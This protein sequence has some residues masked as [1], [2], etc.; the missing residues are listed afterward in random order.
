MPANW[1]TEKYE[2]RSGLHARGLGSTG[3]NA[4][5][6]AKEGSGVQGIDMQAD[7]LEGVWKAYKESWTST[8][9]MQRAETRVWHAL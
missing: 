1:R 5:V 9:C 3:E 6:H 4:E 8:K 7:E 2:R